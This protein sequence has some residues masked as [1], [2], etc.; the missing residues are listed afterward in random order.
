[1]GGH[2]EHH[3]VKSTS[4]RR[5][6]TRVFYGDHRKPPSTEALSGALG[7]LESQAIYDG[8][9][10][11][12]HVRCAEL[13]GSLYLDLCDED[14][15]VV[16]ID[17]TGWRIITNPPV[18]L[19]R[20]AGL[21]SLPEPRRGG[22]ID[23]LGNHVTVK[24][25]D[26]VLLVMWFVAALRASGPYPILAL[27]GEQ[28]SANSTLAR[29]A[30]MLVDPHVSPLRS[31]PRE[32]RDLMIS[33]VNSWVVAIDNISS[34]PSWLSDGLCRLATGGG[35]ATRTLYSNEE[36]T[37][38]DA[39]RPVILN[40]IVDY[41][42][43]GDLIDRCL[44]LHLPTI[45]EPQRK[46]EREFWRTFEAD[47]PLI[48]GALLDA[49]AGALRCLPQVRPASLPRMA[50]F[51][52]WG[53]AACQG[54]GRDADAFL[55]AYSGNRRDA[56]ESI[57]EDSPV[58]SAIRRFVEQSPSW[59]GT[60]TELLGELA[61]VAGEKVVA[62]PR[63]PKTGRKLSGDLRRL[64]PTLRMVGV[65]VEF[66]NRKNTGRLLTVSL[67]EKV[68]N[69]PSP[70]SPPSPASKSP[71]QSGDGMQTR[72]SPT[73]TIPSPI[74]PGKTQGRDGG[75]GSDGRIPTLSG[76]LDDPPF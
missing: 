50:D 35:Y 43:R 71:H 11:P 2:S 57:L 25:D 18:R 52:I 24:G 6:L 55:N 27:T 30:R 23:L 12:V 74:P 36:E 16:E 48:L 22:S 7:V 59:S 56:H 51:A 8:P 32:A 64:A 33:A 17:A 10:H 72:P 13:N 29:L 42:S 61:A 47:S 5:W 70:P 4:M 58:A 73:V 31:E 40:G 63:W 38:L 62:T 60:A 1:V 28:G 19:R 45:P 41:V 69:Q 76:D 20:P 26:L 39:Q 67:L 46:A 66:P 44:F 15:R 75:D 54:L 14:W 68:G 65:C 49:T 3:E 9:E 34:I 53:Q 37:F 21:R